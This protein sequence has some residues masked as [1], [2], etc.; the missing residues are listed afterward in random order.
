MGRFY[1]VGF[2]VLGVLRHFRVQGLGFGSATLPSRR[3]HEF[4]EVI[5]QE[6][7]P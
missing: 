6:L 2:R 5:S 1:G 4:A 7:V 3:P